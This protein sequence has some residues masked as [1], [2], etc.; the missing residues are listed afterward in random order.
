MP[1]AS[2]STANWPTTPLPAS[3]RVRTIFPGMIGAIMIQFA[4]CGGWI[5]SVTDV[6]AASPAQRVARF[7][8]GGD[9]RIPDFRHAFIGRQHQQDVALLGGCGNFHRLEAF[10]DR[11]FA[12]FV[13]AISHDDIHAAVPQVQRL[14]AALVAVS[15]YRHG[16][17]VERGERNIGVI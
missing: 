15:E 14:S 11:Q 1:V 3:Y 12:V 17:A 5:K 16:F 6:V 7:D 2:F 8:A 10:F 4:S 13:V 9:L